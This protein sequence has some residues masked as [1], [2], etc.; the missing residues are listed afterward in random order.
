MAPGEVLIA[1]GDERR[2]LHVVLTG[3][4][5]VHLEGPTTPPVAIIE[6]GASVGELGIIDGEP[7]SAYVVAA[8]D[9]ALLE[10]S[11]EEFWDLVSASRAFARNLLQGLSSRLRANNRT[12]TTE[13]RRRRRFEHAATNDRCTASVTAE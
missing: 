7:G 1:A 8:H 4:L 3:R 5:S 11:D 12:V 9:V 13:S 2:E 6:A 10:I